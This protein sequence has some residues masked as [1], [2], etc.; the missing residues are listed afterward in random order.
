MSV[1]L[2]VQAAFGQPWNQAKPLWTDITE[3]VRHNPP[4]R[5]NRGLGRV[6]RGR[7]GECSFTLDNTSRLF[8]PD[9][10]AGTYAGELVPMVPLRVKGY[11]A[12]GARQWMEGASNRATSD[13]TTAI[14]GDISFVARIRLS[15][16]TPSANQPIVAQYSTAGTRNFRLSVF[17]SGV[18]RFLYST[19]GTATA[20]IDSTTSLSSV[21][22]AND[23]V[24]VRLMF[25]QNSGAGNYLATF[26]YSL[27]D[28]DDWTQV[29][30]TNLGTP[31]AST[32]PANRFASTTAHTVGYSGGPDLYFSGDVA[33]V[34][35]WN[36]ADT[37][38]TPVYDPDFA[39]PAEWSA[40]DGVG[41]ARDD[42]QGN[43]WTLGGDASIDEAGYGV[44]RGFVSEWR[45]EGDGRDSV[46]AVSAVDGLSVLELL[47][48]PPTYE[49]LVAADSP[50]GWWQLDE[51]TGTTATDS[52]SAGVNGTYV[53]TPALGESGPL[54]GMLA[55]D[56]ENGSSEYVTV[57]SLTGSNVANAWTIE[58]WLNQESDISGIAL[59]QIDTNAGARGY[60]IRMSSGGFNFAIQYPTGTGVND[61]N[62]YNWTNTDTTL[63]A[64]HH[65]ALNYNGSTGWTL[66]MDGADMGTVTPVDFSPSSVSG[67][68]TAEIGRRND[69][70][71]SGGFWDGKLAQ[72]A[73][74]QPPLSVS[75]I[76]AHAAAD[77]NGR[78]AET[79]ST[80]VTA[81]L[82]YVG[83][84]TAQRNITT[85]TTTI[86]TY[87][88]ETSALDAL[89]QAADT[90]NSQIWIDGDGNLTFTNRN[91]RGSATSS[92]T[93][94]NDGSDIG[95]QDLTAT[96]DDTLL[97]TVAQI[98]DLNNDTLQ[99]AHS[100]TT[101]YGPRVISRTTLTTDT[102]EPADYA[103]WLLGEYATP[104]TQ[105]TILTVA[106]SQ[107]ERDLGDLITLEYG[108]RA[109]GAQ[110]VWQ[111][112]V[113][114]IT[115]VA[116]TEMWRTR[117]GLSNADGQGTFTLNNDTFGELNGIGR[118]GF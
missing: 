55:A 48:I 74:H 31:G 96:R 90:E 103:N 79:T 23:W 87:T 66:Y 76:R 29:S 113:D 10:A 89:W 81:I 16:W 60:L 83:W 94:S 44:F 25:D 6:S 32:S 46:T 105:A 53:N 95:Y 5:V 118:L 111:A 116:D 40:E 28:T 1:E 45:V 33:T 97:R 91:T 38:G 88:G 93:Y 19:D 86:T 54:T 80:R 27:D 102:S 18:V 77:F 92:A 98:I 35:V 24:W 106:D 8:D 17:T 63:G 59:F 75:R 68:I 36:A 112:F 56:F 84:P 47:Q 107:I 30:W 115:V 20:N 26:Q 21:A 72:V 9:Y 62:I 22:A 61:F 82:D 104:L 85:G 101:T 70:L 14:V 100:N 2:A 65:V 58:M 34:L 108:H 117:L 52:G 57:G 49:S 99:I 3:H 51:T 73:V 15:D 43:T 69:T 109:G 41:S 37:S 42:G 78:P 11:S 110:T 39:D 7:P 4:L 114:Q 13:Y 12:A 50:L 71:G 64:W 67:T